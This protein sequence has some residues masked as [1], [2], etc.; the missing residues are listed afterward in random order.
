MRQF[1]NE[2]YILRS[3]TDSASLKYQGHYWLIT[4]DI[5]CYIH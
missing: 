5:D 3:L 1:D 2:N 4:S